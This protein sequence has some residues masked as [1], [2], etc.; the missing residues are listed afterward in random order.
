MT[1]DVASRPASDSWRRLA[2]AAPRR[3]EHLAVL[4]RSLERSRTSLGGE[5]L[6]FDAHE[7]CVLIDRRLP[8]LIDRELDNLAPDDRN[9]ERQLD[10]LVSLIEQFARHCSRR[11]SDSASDSR[12]DAEVLRRRFEARLSSAPDLLPGPDGRA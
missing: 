7:L 8:E 5:T 11:R 9:R 3:I 2:A 1:V 12:Y 6:D 10:E 4:Q